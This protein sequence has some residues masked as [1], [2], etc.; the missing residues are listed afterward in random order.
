MTLSHSRKA[1]PLFLLLILSTTSIQH[2]VAQPTTGEVRGKVVDASTNEPLIGAQ[3][4]IRDTKTGTTTTISGEYVLRRLEPG[5]YTIIARYIGYKSLSRV[6]KVQAGVTASADFAL[7]PTTVQA[8]EL[9]VTGVG[10]ATEK[11]RLSAPVDA[12]TQE[13]IERTPTNSIDQLMQGQVAGV[14]IG[15]AS[16]L[17]GTGSRI[18]TRG[19]KSAVANTLPIVYVDGVRVDVG[20]N[21]GVGTG[22]TVSSSLAQLVTGEI[23]RIE[24]VRGGAGATLYGSQA[25]NGVIQ[26]FTKK[27]KAGQTRFKVAAQT[28]VDSPE[29][30]FIPDDF[31]PSLLFQNGFF[32]Q[33]TANINGG[34]DNVTYN[35]SGSARSNRGFLSKDQAQDELQNVAAGVRAILSDKLDAEFSTS[36]IRNSFGRVNQGNNIF[37]LL[38]GLT[39]GNNF[40]SNTIAAAGTDNRD[41]LFSIWQLPEYRE[42]VNRSINSLTFGFNPFK[43]FSNK[44]TVGLDY[45]KREARFQTPIQTSQAFGAAPTALGTIVRSD[46]EFLQLSLNYVGS[47]KLPDFGP[48]SN[49]ISLVGEGI[50]NNER[51]IGGTGTGLAAGTRD[52]DQSGT[53]TG[54]EG[55]SGIFFGGIA[56]QDQ[57]GISNNIFLDLGLRLDVSTAFGRDVATVFAPKVGA[58]INLSDFDFYPESMKSILSS[59]KLRG[60][61]GR[62][63]NTPPPFTRDRTFGAPSFLGTAA[64][65]FANPGDPTL[66][67]EITTTIEGGFDAGF[68]NDRVSLEFTYSDARTTDALFAVPNDPV[69]GL[70][71]QLRNVGGL[72]NL[73]FEL[74]LKANVYQ[75]ENVDIQARLNFSS[76]YAVITNMT[77]ANGRPIPDFAAG[78]FAFAGLRIAPNRAPGAFRANRLAQEA[79]GTFRGRIIFDQ[80][81]GAQPIPSRFGSFSFDITLFKDFSISA[82]A[83]FSWGNS[84]LNV[85]EPLRMNAGFENSLRRIP[86]FVSIVNAGAQPGAA[87]SIPGNFQSFGYFFIEDARW[88]KI[89]DI[90]FRYRNV[91][92]QLGIRNLVFTASVRNPIIFG[93][94]TT[95]VDPE[96]NWARFGGDIDL[97]STAGANYSAPR[98]WRF[99]LEYS[100]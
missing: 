91:L 82:M 63:G 26:I 3:V 46:R 10:T 39:T 61:Y 33:Y 92:S 12:I 84:V 80:F 95:G 43:E 28:G 49:T 22:G 78:G 59:V 20:D 87:V 47:I 75:A 66:K 67:P 30:K 1:F 5:E 4:S 29:L 23:E 14:S 32:Q 24:V 2:A 99:G 64:L 34:A 90:T 79:D 85:L 45:N 19:V 35:I 69:T 11:R 40:R 37:S 71:N 81:N 76:V 17:P 51:V 7:T 25:A 31:P 55:G 57:I 86:G 77:D 89:R 54:F 36:F 48:V 9:V 60:A 98:M 21:F 38:G 52:F 42:D 27:G 18:Q 15:M 97:G 100:F 68:F 65:T 62:A 83:E 72:A 58:S 94:Q 8:D 73:V 41:S 56:I 93:T 16:G 13:Q 70:G 50:R 96:V 44:L 6:V 88:I 74:S 53:V